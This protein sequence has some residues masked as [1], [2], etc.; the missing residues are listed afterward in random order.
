MKEL[1]KMSVHRALSELKTYDDRIQRALNANFVLANKKSNLKISGK[2]IQEVE[3]LIQGNYDSVVALFENKKVI[4]SAVILSNAQTKVEIDGVEYTIAE[5]IERKSM[6]N[7]E[8][9]FLQQ[10]QSQFSGNNNKVEQENNKV[11]NNV[12]NYLQSILGEKDKRTPEDIETYTK[13]YLKMNEY[14]LINP[15]DIAKKIDDLYNRIKTFE[16]EIDYKLS[17]SNA[18]TFIEV[19]LTN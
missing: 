17:E 10:L 15:C 1:V 7:L 18:T 11:A 14:E 8:K 3:Q 4:K 12:E 6:L 16:T 2:T 5:A 9:S 13:S 19:D